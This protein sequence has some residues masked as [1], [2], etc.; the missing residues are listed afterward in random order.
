MTNKFDY[1]NAA[2]TANEIVDFFG[3][4]ASITR[5]TESAIDPATGASQQGVNATLNGTMTP[6]IPT[7]VVSDGG[8]VKSIG[9]AYWVGAAIMIG[10][11]FGSSRVESLE[12]TKSPKSDLIVQKL[13]FNG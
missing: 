11:Y 8:V 1:I 2:F 13:V 5:Q 10:D 3:S 6:I 9:V 12:V 4:S 7:T